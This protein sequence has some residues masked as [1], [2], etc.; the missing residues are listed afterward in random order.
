[1]PL[2]TTTFQT[3]AVLGHPQRRG[4][5]HIVTGLLH[6]LKEMQCQVLLEERLAVLIGNPEQP[7]FSTEDLAQ[8]VDLAIV[9]GGDGSMLRVSRL[10]S[11]SSTA[12]VGMNMGNLGF[13]TDLSPFDYHMALKQVIEGQFETEDR[14]LIEA[15]VLD[16]NQRCRQS[17]KALN[18]IV[19]HPSKVAHMITFEVYIDGKFM[20]SQRADGMIIA[21]PTGS[22]AYALS[23]GGP[24]ITPGIDALNIIPMFPHTLSS[25][26]IVVSGQSE[27][28]LIP[29]PDRNQDPI[30]VSFDSQVTLELKASEQLVI[31]KHDKPLHIIHPPGYSF[32]HILRNK[33]GW[34]SKL[35]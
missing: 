2:N 6:F 21:T 18:E 33:L 10:F 11:G 4:M 35:T 1:M 20:Y 19:L 3:I 9:I 22:T 29:S 31:K 32:F 23:A 26:P 30:Q 25:R 24:I 34:G 27:V 15:Q 5:Q 8:K 16:A 13:L 12:V 28:A 17:S 7:I 14:F